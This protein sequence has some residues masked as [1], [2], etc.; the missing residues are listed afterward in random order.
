MHVEHIRLSGPTGETWAVDG[1]V[2]GTC[3]PDGGGVAATWACDGAVGSW[4]CD[5]A[6]GSWACDGAVG[7]WACDGVVGFSARDDVVGSWAHGGVVGSF[8]PSDDGVHFVLFDVG[9][10]GIF[11]F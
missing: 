4:A 10:E 7:S 2:V 3:A 6:V 8:E 9:F 1:S 11:L 5:G